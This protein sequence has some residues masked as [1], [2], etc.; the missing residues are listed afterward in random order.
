M[1]IIIP[2]E[3]SDEISALEPYLRY[4]EYL[5]YVP[6]D[7]APADVAPRL[8]DVRSAYDS[9]KKNQGIA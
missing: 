4:D 5:G 8:R 3:I 1:R 6:K 2:K 9:Y 7:D